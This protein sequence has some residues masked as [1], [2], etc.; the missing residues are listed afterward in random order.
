MAL[1]WRLNDLAVKG[2]YTIH[3]I[4]VLLEQMDAKMVNLEASLIPADTLQRITGLD[5]GYNSQFVDGFAE[6]DEPKRQAMLNTW[7][8]WYDARR[9]TDGR[10]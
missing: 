9:L 2:V 10:F 3:E 5:L 1:R 8:A 6:E 7:R 4:P